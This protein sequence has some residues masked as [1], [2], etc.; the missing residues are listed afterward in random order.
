[1]APNRKRDLVVASAAVMVCVL[2]NVVLWALHGSRRVAIP[3]EKPS[4]YFT[5]SDGARA[6]ALL[7]KETGRAP[8]LWRR[9]FTLLSSAPELKD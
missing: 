2:I 7:L 5:D 4:V 9:P 6:M 3:L 1:M 8:A